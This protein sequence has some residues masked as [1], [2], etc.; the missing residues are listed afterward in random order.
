[1][2]NFPIRY[3]EDNFIFNESSKKDGE[4]NG[5]KEQCSNDEINDNGKAERSLQI[6]LIIGTIELGSIYSRTFHYTEGNAGT[7]V[8][9]LRSYTNRR[10][11]ANGRYHHG[12]NH[13]HGT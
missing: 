3:F 4:N 5:Q 9:K 11:H 13:A 8:S 7:D 1:M 2:Y 6:L 10:N 12:I